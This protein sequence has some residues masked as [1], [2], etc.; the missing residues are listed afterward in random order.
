MEIIAFLLII[1]GTAG[2]L[3]NEFVVEWG[4][5]AAFIFG[6]FNV[7]GLAMLIAFRGRGDDAGTRESR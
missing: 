7:V 3:A 6:G 4:R 1:L 2:L 5:I